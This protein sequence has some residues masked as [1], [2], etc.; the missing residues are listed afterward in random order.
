MKQKLLKSMLLLCVLVGGISSA[1]ADVVTFDATKDISADASSY[2]SSELTISAGDGSTWKANGYGA[3]NKKNIIIGKGGA[4]YLET[5]NVSGTITSVAVTWSGNANYYLALQTTSGTELEAKSNPSSSSTQT[6]VVSGSYSQLRLVGRRSSGTSNAAATITKVVVTYAPSGGSLTPCVDVSSITL[7]PGDFDIKGHR[8]GTFAADGTKADEGATFS[9]STTATSGLTVESDGSYTASAA[10]SYTVKVTATP[11][12][13]DKYSAVVKDFDITLTDTR[14][15]CGL[16]FTPSSYDAILG[17]DFD[18]P[19]ITNPNS[20][21]VTYSSSPA[22][23]ATVN[24]STGAVTLL[25]E[26][27][28][29]ITAT[30]EGNDNCKGG[31]ASYTLTIIDP[32]KKVFNFENKASDYG[33]GVTTTTDGSAYVETEKTWTLDGVTIVTAGKYRWWDAD[34]TLRFYSTDPQSKMTI[35]APTGKVITNIAI[36]GGQQFISNDG[37]YSSSNGKWAGQATSVVLTYNASKSVNVKTI[38]VTIGDP[39]D[40]TIT[41]GSALYTT[42]TTQVPVSFTGVK[43]YTVS[44]ISGSSAIL[45]KVTEAPANTPVIIEAAAANTYT[46]TYKS[47]AAGVGTNYLKYSDGTIVGDGSTIFALG[48]KNDKVGFYLVKNGVIVPAGRAY[49]VVGGGGEVKEFLYFDFGGD[50]ATAINEVGDSK[51]I[52][53]GP[54]YDLSGR[55]IQKPTKGL[56]IVNG[57]K[58]M[59]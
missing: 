2:Q 1:W 6:F 18:T 19:T 29:T 47:D 59:F 42:Y 7:E 51:S 21:T 14:S 56:Y 49:L 10:G 43:A 5:P 40:P 25:K 55:C 48:E 32:N 36:T 13:G 37:A 24:A 46:L 50:D 16:A 3:T 30:G 34:G 33:S 41:V 4:N 11:S 39:T 58:I 35:S 12:D 17:E 8:T 57:K 20:L 28:V 44:S 15:A 53:N 45:T 52:V 31:S 38:S 26:G 9:Y 54:V 27:T 22:S 23:V